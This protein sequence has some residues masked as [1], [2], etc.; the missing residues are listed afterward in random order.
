MELEELQ[1]TEAIKRLQILQQEYKIHPNVINEFRQFGI[2]YYSERVNKLYDGILYW[3]KNKAEFF[4]AVK[5]AENKYNIYVS[6]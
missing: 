1:K 3:I 6:V 5:D 2:V 4:K